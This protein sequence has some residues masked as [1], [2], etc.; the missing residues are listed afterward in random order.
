VCTGPGVKL[1]KD[2]DPALTGTTVWDG[3]VLLSHYLTETDTLLHHAKEVA[4]VKARAAQQAAAES[5]QLT[6]GGPESIQQGAAEGSNDSASASSAALSVTTQPAGVSQPSFTLHPPTSST[7]Q[8]GSL[9]PSQRLAA[10]VPGVQGPGT[11]HCLEL[12]AGTGAVSLALVAC[13]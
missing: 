3:A 13:R 10:P 11:L 2:R 1:D 5:L 8:Q 7:A 9:V 12:G 4:E 6:N